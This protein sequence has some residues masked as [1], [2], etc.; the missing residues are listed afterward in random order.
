MT[1]IRIR[2]YLT[3]HHGI[4]ASWVTSSS[5]REDSKR[6][7]SEDARAR[8]SGPSVPSSKE[9]GSCNSQQWQLEV[10]RYLIH[11]IHVIEYLMFVQYISLYIYGFRTKGGCFFFKAQEVL[12][13]ARFILSGNQTKRYEGW[14]WSN[15]N[16]APPTQW[17]CSSRWG[18][19]QPVPA[20]VS[21]LRA[22]RNGGPTH[23][24]IPWNSPTRNTSKIRQTT[25]KVLLEHP[26]NSLR[27]DVILVP[28]FSTSK[29][30]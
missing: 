6:H 24:F 14:I 17:R 28:C 4:R 10:E 5:K 25:S 30:Q 29:I 16:M 18:A 8:P 22:F 12:H 13:L 27:V 9:P 2:T 7:P 19:R 23:Q 15:Q 20:K 26:C 11:V 21:G 1:S 3:N